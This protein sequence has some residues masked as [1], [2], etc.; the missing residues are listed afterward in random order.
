MSY[1]DDAVFTAAT[2]Y[3]FTG[4]VGNAAPTPQ[5]LTT[6]DFE[7]YGVDDVE[8]GWVT[9]GHTSE[10][11][12]PEF[13]F[14]GGDKETR[15]TWQKKNLREVSTDTPVD[16]LL[17]RAQQFDSE[18]LELYYG[19]NVSSEAGI[20]SVNSSD[21]PSLTRGLLLVL[22]D[23][24]HRIGFYAPKTSIRRDD[25]ISL[26]TDGFGTLPLRATLTKETG[27]PLFSWV[28]PHELPETPEP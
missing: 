21:A 10:E 15:G 22:V 11:D 12:L 17:M 23:G 28:L 9:L 19:E 2:G 7:T 18:T 16:Y 8:S 27:K 3:I 5:E 20:Y 14:D 25:S 6:L 26:A 13:G 1:N 24:P 4:P